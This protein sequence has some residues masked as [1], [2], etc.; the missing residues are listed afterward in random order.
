MKFQGLD[1]ENENF[2]DNANVQL[3]V[4]KMTNH[5]NIYSLPYFQMKITIIYN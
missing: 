2:W 1:G 4:C 3:N 5:H